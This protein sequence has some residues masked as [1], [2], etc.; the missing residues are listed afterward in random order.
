MFGLE[1][2]RKNVAR[3]LKCEKTVEAEDRL[4]ATEVSGLESTD[5]QNRTFLGEVLEEHAIQKLKPAE[6]AVMLSST[7]LDEARKHYKAFLGA[8]DEHLKSCEAETE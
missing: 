8:H 4:L 5:Q 1:L 2:H 6:D 3:R 7:K